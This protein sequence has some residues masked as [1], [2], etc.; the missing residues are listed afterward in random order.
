MEGCFTFQW[1]AECFSLGRSSFLS[2]GCT[3][4]GASFLMGVQ[5][6]SWDRGGA[7]FNPV[8]KG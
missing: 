2:G 7:F 5:K 3:P 8:N 4:W 1:G 6:K